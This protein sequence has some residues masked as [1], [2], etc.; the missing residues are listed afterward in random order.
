MSTPTACLPNH[1]S[2]AIEACGCNSPR[3]DIVDAMTLAKAYVTAGIAAGV[4]LGHGPGPVGHTDFPQLYSHFP[5]IV[6][7]PNN[8]ATPPMFALAFMGRLLI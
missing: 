6:A 3:Y 5:R 4:G 8:T 1:D 2:F 7:D